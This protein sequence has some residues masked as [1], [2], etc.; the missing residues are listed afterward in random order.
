MDGFA[1]SHAGVRRTSDSAD[2]PCRGH[3]DDVIDAG[4]ALSRPGIAEKGH[5]WME[6]AAHKAAVDPHVR[7]I[8]CGSEI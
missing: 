6:T 4:L 5:F 3:A 1:Q 8:I 7:L 2:R